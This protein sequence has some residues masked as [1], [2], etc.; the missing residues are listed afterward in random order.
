MNHNEF[1]LPEHHP[2]SWSR[3]VLEAEICQDGYDKLVLKNQ[4][5]VGIRLAIPLVAIY[6]SMHEIKRVKMISST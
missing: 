4:P 5:E 1:C 6:I 3:V 2:Q